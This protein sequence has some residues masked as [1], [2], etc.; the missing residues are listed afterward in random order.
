MEILINISGWAG[1]VLIV[2]A[3]Y[4]VSANKIPVTDKNY[5]WL[6]LVGSVLLGVNVLSRQAWPA[7]ALEVVWGVIAIMA[8][9]KLR[10]K[11]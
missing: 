6:N 2:I 8:L 10:M 1:T 11:N 9:A 7:F 3:Y 5:Q 4:L